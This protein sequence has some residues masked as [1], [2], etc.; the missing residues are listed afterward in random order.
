[1]PIN[2][3]NPY[4]SPASASDDLVPPI[5]WRVVGAMS[6][7]VGVLGFVFGACGVA[8]LMYDF[9]IGRP[10][11]HLGRMFAGTVLFLV[12]A[13]SFVVAGQFYRRGRVLPGLV[14]NGAGL[15]MLFAGEWI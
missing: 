2:I 7:A 9:W 11:P 1:M 8:L 6:T 12:F 4:A 5:R 3:D 14:T 13:G 10:T 15:L